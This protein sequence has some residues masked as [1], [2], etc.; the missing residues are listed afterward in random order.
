M[1]RKVRSDC[2]ACIVAVANTHLYWAPKPRISLCFRNVRFRFG[3][4]SFF[5]YMD[6]RIRPSQNSN[7][8]FEHPCF[9]FAV[10]LC[11]FCNPFRSGWSYS[12]IETYICVDG[13]VRLCS[14]ASNRSQQLLL[15][16]TGGGDSVIKFIYACMFCVDDALQSF[17]H[18][19]HR[20][21]LITPDQNVEK[22]RASSARL[23]IDNAVDSRHNRGMTRTTASFPSLLSP[24][25]IPR[26]PSFPQASFGPAKFFSAQCPLRL[27]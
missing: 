4:F 19:D 10:L 12:C 6:Q 25:A 24:S 21:G 23:L 15:S 7:T 13:L 14:L 17:P 1:F 2:E 5:G 8:V 26:C 11:G 27:P 9:S 18:T 16:L 3:I 20:D 22:Q